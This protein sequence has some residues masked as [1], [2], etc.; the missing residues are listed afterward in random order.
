MS[1]QS[2]YCH[3]VGAPLFGNSVR[4]GGDSL[5]ISIDLP[6]VVILLDQ[7]G[8]FGQGLYSCKERDR[9][10]GI[11]NY[12]YAVRAENHEVSISVLPRV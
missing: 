4:L 7:P 5:V 12:P 3:S 11:W 2:F 9:E 10:S 1:P 6:V 8:T